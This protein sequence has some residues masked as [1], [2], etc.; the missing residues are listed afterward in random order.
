[1]NEKIQKEI[2]AKFND[3]NAGIAAEYGVNVAAQGMLSLV[4]AQ[5]AETTSE[6]KESPEDAA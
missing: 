6:E 1:M 4:P 5:K 2:E 3:F